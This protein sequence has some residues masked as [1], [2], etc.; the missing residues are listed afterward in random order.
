MGTPFSVTQNVSKV[1]ANDYQSTAAVPTYYSFSTIVNGN[2]N[3]HQTFCGI[4]MRDYRFFGS[5]YQ[6]IR[7]GFFQ[8]DLS[9]LPV[10]NVVQI[11]TLTV[12]EVSGGGTIDITAADFGDAIFTLSPVEGLVVSDYENSK[13]AP[14]ITVPIKFIANNSGPYTVNVIPNMIPTGGIVFVGFRSLADFTNT[15]PGWWQSPPIVGP[16]YSQWLCAIDQGVLSGEYGP[17]P[18]GSTTGSV[19]YGNYRRIIYRNNPKG[20]VG[21]DIL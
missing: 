9:S 12:R 10:G 21:G 15:T 19:D 18:A 11:G 16:P 7:R 5:N 17:L 3:T 4:E 8:F 2:G 6:W 1:Y 14:A 20:Y 13:N